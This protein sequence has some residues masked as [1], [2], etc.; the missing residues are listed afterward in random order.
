MAVKEADIRGEELAKGDAEGE[1]EPRAEPVGG[2]TVTDGLR[3]VEE[4]GD[5]E[6]SGRTEVEAEG[7]TDACQLPLAQPL[8]VG[9]SSPRSESKGLVLAVAVVLAGPKEA[10]MEGLLLAER[11]PP[12]VALTHGE[13]CTVPVPVLQRECE[14]LGVPLGVRWMEG[15]G[16]AQ[17]VADGDTDAEL[18][19]EG[20]R[21]SCRDKDMA[22]EPVLLCVGSSTL[23]EAPP[24]TL[25]EGA[26]LVGD[27]LDEPLTEALCEGVRHTEADG[28]A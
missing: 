22:S 13:E 11:L 28:D 20:L 16:V 9:V 26:A 17:R 23:G 12:P 3:V 7:D 15:E 10:D 24:D 27:R 1:G 21:E 6:I 14:G 2:T 8:A 18:D 19:T 4:Q 5:K 25:R